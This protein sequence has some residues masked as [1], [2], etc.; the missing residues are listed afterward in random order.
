MHALTLYVQQALIYP[1]SVGPKGSRI[2]RLPITLKRNNMAQQQSMM[3]P[4]VA[5]AKKAV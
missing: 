2:L 1:G 4:R 5:G 3:G